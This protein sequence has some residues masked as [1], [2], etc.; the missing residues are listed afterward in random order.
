MKK[1]IENN[2][3]G[4]NWHYVQKG[5]LIQVQLSTIEDVL[6]IDK[7]DPK[8]W[9]ALAC[10][11]KGLE[12]SEETLNLLD[13]DKNGRVRIP[14]ILA[15]VEYIKKYFAKPEVIMT[16]GDSIPLDALGDTTF[17]CGHS[18][19]DSAK[20]ILEILG[21]PDATEI[22]ISD[23]SVND[24]LFSPGIINGDGVLPP[25]CIKDDFLKDIVKEIINFS[26]GCEDISGVKGINRK[27]YEDFFN[28][29]EAIKQWR[30]SAAIDD[31]KIFF[32]K[33]QTDNAA[34]AFSKVKDK[35]NDYYLRCSLINYD[36]NAKEI[37]K[38]Q[39]DSMFLD[40]NGQLRTSDELSN[41]PLA[42]CAAEKP[43]PLDSS[44]NPVWM[45]DMDNFKKNVI[46]PIFKQEITSLTET[47]WRKI[48]SLFEPYLNWCKAMPSSPIA[49]MGLDKITAIFNSPAAEELSK[50][51]EEEEKHPP[52]ALATIELKKLLL[53]RRDFL[54][55]LRNFVSF[56]QFYDLNEAAIFQCGTLYIDGRSC[57][58]C[59]KVLDMA[60]HGTMAALSQCYLI[61]CDC[62]KV[63]TGEKMQIAALISDGNT[64]NL[65]VGR[66]GVFFDRN[67]KDWDATIIKIIDNPVSIKQAFWSPYKRLLRLIQEKIAK[68]AAKA[69]SSVM[70]KMSKTVEDP[71]MAASTKKTDIGTVAAISVAF[72]GI[73]TVVGGLLQAFLGLGCWIPLGIIGIM[74]AIS[75]PSVFIAWRKLKQR[76]IA[77]ILDASGWAVNGNVKIT[78]ALGAKL[79]HLPE[80]P[81]SAYI[82]SIDPFAQKKSPVKRII[83]WL[84]IALIVGLLIF[85]QIKLPDGLAGLWI[86][87]K[88]WFTLH[89]PKV[90]TSALEQSLENLGT[91]N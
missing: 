35:I 28:E 51:L 67:G 64:D 14:E 25:E 11:V 33:D 61:Y 80:R 88:E 5:G 82:S 87:I 71:K 4:Y 38:K 15:G 6:N 81:A 34:A 91:M 83:F 53:Y 7:L 63:G 9:T 18:P 84:V 1:I 79:T 69:E 31:P 58:L 26:G 19:L 59:F 74:L 10:P 30:E 27:Q 89:G 78:T 48:E 32:L 55:L 45:A 52:I 50:L 43:L 72:T 56:E 22:A 42:S 39:T 65:L 44:I 73:A 47:H 17:A 57:D 66:N 13:T 36:E 8:S 40:E 29:L 49:N 76:N 16:P 62:I 77:P 20:A 21:K 70:D 54:N 60:K 2:K 41:L 37:L 23:I 3:E 90:D 24:K 46:L 68:S 75:L 85:L 12:F 86:K